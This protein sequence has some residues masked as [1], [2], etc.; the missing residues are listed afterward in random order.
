MLPR[1]LSPPISR[2]SLTG[3]EIDFMFSAIKDQALDRAVR[4]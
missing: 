4:G 3:S 1:A 2:R